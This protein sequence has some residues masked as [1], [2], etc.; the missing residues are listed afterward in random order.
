MAKFMWQTITTSND[1]NT[2]FDGILG[3]GRDSDYYVGECYVKELFKANLISQEKFS[4]GLKNWPDGGTIDF[5]PPDTSAI[6][7]GS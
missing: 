1:T 5:G 7:D 3:L 4:I 6:A 2:A